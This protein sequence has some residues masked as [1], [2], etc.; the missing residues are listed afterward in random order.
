[1]A[2]IDTFKVILN[3]DYDLGRGSDPRCWYGGCVPDTIERLALKNQY[4]TQGRVVR[5]RAD[6]LLLKSTNL[7]AITIQFLGIPQILKH[8]GG[9]I[10][11]LS[12]CSH[13]HKGVN[14]Q[15]IL[16][17]HTNSP[18]S[19]SWN[20]SGCTSGSTASTASMSDVPKIIIC[21]T[22]TITLV[23][24]IFNLYLLARTDLYPMAHYATWDDVWKGE[25]L[26]TT[27]GYPISILLYPAS[28]RC[29]F[30]IQGEERPRL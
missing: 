17:L 4:Q 5:F 13:L 12:S 11:I 27:V 16:P 14:A 28:T 19:L 29:C 1:M 25:W 8:R 6:Q 30:E 21:V 18:L 20:Y 2:T 9:R 15:H 23:L 10:V 24:V 26:D 3:K 7:N 22:V